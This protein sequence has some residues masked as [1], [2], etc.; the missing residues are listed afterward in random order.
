[1]FYDRSSNYRIPD[2][3]EF[4]APSEA[5]NMYNNRSSNATFSK[6]NPLDAGVGLVVGV[7][8]FYGVVALIGFVS[9]IFILVTV[10]RS[11]VTRNTVNV[12]LSSLAFS[13]LVMILLSLFD[14]FAFV[15]GGGWEYGEWTCKIQS[16]F[17]EVMFTASTLTLVAV[18]CERYLLICHP[19]MKRRT[20][21]AIYRILCVVWLSALILCSPLLHGYIVFV[22]KDL[23][24]NTQQ[25]VCTNRN[26]SDKHLRIF[27][28]VYSIITYLIPLMI[29][30]FAHWQISM[31]V[32]D[33]G[34]RSSTAQNTLQSDNS[35]VC[36]TIREESSNGSDVTNDSKKSGKC[37]GVHKALLSQINSLKRKAT[38]NNVDRDYNRREKRLK[39]VK[40]LFV[41]TVVFLILWTPFIIMRMLLLSGVNIHDFVYKF[42]EILIFSSTAVNGFIYAFMSPPFRK[43]FKALM[44]CQI[45]REFVS[46]D[47]APSMSNS[48]DN[49]LVTHRL[50][51]RGSSVSYHVELTKANHTSN[52]AISS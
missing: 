12:F 15:Q 49:R 38:Q 4:V 26:W 39:A 30:A 42:S 14:C 13:D 48:E 34:R 8:L 1:M 43:A 27:Y 19:H 36:F 40:L 21:N 16:Y 28:G 33:N 23:V 7:V 45:R 41:V 44:C 10:F 9:N 51:S 29:M 11:M 6:N 46:R 18:S 2:G 52:G 35:T 47:S 50:N 24:K 20:I 22:D 32:K 5:L 37:N 25:K 3:H 31:S 17:L